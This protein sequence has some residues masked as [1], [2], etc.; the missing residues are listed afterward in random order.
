MIIV[1][2]DEDRE[3]EGDLVMAAEKVSPDAVNFMAKHGRGL[4]CLTLPRERVIERIA[5]K[6]TSL[7]Q[8]LAE[9]TAIHGFTVTDPARR[10]TLSRR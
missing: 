6:H 7:D 9:R 10:G 8:E 2:D 4:I 3:N 5:E 1:T